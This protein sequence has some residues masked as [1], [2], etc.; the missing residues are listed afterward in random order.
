MCQ[1][2]KS[3][4]VELRF[5]VPHKRVAVYK[6]WVQ[7]K[8]SSAEWISSFEAIM[9]AIVCA[10]LYEK[11]ATSM[12]IPVVMNLRNRTTCY[13]PEFFGNASMCDVND[14][15]QVVVDYSKAPEE[16]IIQVTEQ[17]HHFIRNKIGYSKD[18]ASF[19]PTFEFKI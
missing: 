2:Y 15:A 1:K 17:L 3:S 6:D 9:G 16:N 4:C 10:M 19:Y 5:R 11:K 18:V 7:S 14:R 8:L 12:K 13:G